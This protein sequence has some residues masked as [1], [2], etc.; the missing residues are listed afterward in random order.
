[1]EKRILIVAMMAIVLIFSGC[2]AMQIGDNM[3]E[4]TTQTWDNMDES[5]TVTYKG[6][7]ISLY[8]TKESI[9][10]KYPGNNFSEET[11][12]KWPEQPEDLLI[13]YRNMEING[14]SQEVAVAI[15]IMNPTVDCPY[16]VHVGDSKQKLFDT[17]PE[18]VFEVPEGVPYH[19]IVFDDQGKLI[20]VANGFYEYNEYQIMYYLLNGDLPLPPANQPTG[21]IQAIRLVDCSFFSGKLE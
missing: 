2:S 21:T 19:Y 14:N 7:T 18:A 8:E 4:D 9:D 10:D 3:D 1:M 6:Q 13:T 11:G 17:Y 16:E 15:A 20:P 5:T 12:W